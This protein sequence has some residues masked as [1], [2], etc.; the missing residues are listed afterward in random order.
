MITLPTV[1]SYGHYACPNYGAHCLRVSVGS[2]A[3]YFSY[4]TPVAFEVAG[5]RVVR[6]NV[7]G[8]TTGKH[9]N[10]IDGGDKRSRVSG[11]EFE[12]AL[13]AELESREP[14]CETRA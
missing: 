11:E 12:Q 3:V 2:L 1:K 14:V 8:P 7:W 9:L 4:E 10:A 6:E 5:R 13:A